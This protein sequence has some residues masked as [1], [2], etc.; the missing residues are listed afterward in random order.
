MRDA[1]RYAGGK[2]T[3]LELPGLSHV[4][5]GLGTSER[6]DVRCTSAAFLERW[7]LN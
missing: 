3:L 1:V 4:Y 5:V 6:D 2:A 7:L